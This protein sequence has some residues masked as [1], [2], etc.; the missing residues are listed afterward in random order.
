M[1]RACAE[2]RRQATNRMVG[3]LYA[4]KQ[5]AIP[6]VLASTVSPSP[7]S[8]SL[9][10]SVR[11]LSVRR[12]MVELDEDLPNWAVQPPYILAARARAAKA[13]QYEAQREGGFTDGE[14]ERGEQSAD[15]GSEF[16]D[17]DPEMVGIDSVECAP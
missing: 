5:H 4:E 2:L 15:L 7:V 8:L 12:R 3:V 13:A 9:P 6:S 11:L 17:F 1:G 16:Q 10:A 14:A